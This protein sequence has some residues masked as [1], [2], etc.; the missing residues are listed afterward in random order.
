MRVGRFLVFIT[1]WV[2]L[3]YCPVARWSWDTR[4][5]SKLR[6]AMDFAGGTAVH[7]CSGSSVAAFAVFSQFE[8]RGWTA[9]ATFAQRKLA[10]DLK[11]WRFWRWLSFSKLSNGSDVE[12]RTNSPETSQVPSGR[13]SQS[14]RQQMAAP[15][16]PV[17]DLDH[18]E[19][20]YSINHMVLG[21]ALLWVGWFG[22]NG[23][24]ALGAN[25]RAVSACL[26]TQTAASAGGT[27]GLLLQ[28]ALIRGDRMIQRPDDVLIHTPSMQE[29]CDGV[30]AGLVA[31]TPA[32]GYVRTH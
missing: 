4:G 23:G 25:L 17:P 15:Q 12:L 1:L 32:A 9:T 27:I 10:I 26:A 18:E 11:T 28:W 7:V 5:W 3:V 19:L 31:I 8:D 2:T 30:I 22:F 6:G 24:S 13:N 14:T 16:A 20:P 21:T 29:F